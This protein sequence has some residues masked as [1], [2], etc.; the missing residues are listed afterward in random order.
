[1]PVISAGCS[2]LCG[3]AI[4]ILIYI[5]IYTYFKIELSGDSD[6]KVVRYKCQCVNQNV[7]CSH[8]AA[9]LLYW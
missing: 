3:L 6:Y 8:V 2:H 4:V 7:P 9:C 1:M 5:D